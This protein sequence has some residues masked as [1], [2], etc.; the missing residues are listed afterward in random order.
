ML[1]KYLDVFNK[2]SLLIEF[3]IKLYI[4]DKIYINYKL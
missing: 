1:R 2:K 4:I 3:L